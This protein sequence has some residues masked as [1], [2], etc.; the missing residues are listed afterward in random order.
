VFNP[1]GQGRK[2]DPDGAYVRRW[3]PE[4]A[5]LPGAAVHEPWKHPEGYDAGYPR[6]IVDHDEERRQALARYQAAREQATSEQATSRTA[7][8]GRR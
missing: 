7:S 2:V 8:R 4:L 5:H 3:V 1:V 6:P